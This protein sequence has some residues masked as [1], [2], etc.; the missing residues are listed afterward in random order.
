VFQAKGSVTAEARSPIVVRRVAGTT[1]ADED[2][3]RRRRREVTATGWMD[4]WSSVLVPA[5]TV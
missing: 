3:D 2:V 5:N 4:G 1:R